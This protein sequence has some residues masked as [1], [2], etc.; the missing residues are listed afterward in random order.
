MEIV[1]EMFSHEERIKKVGGR[2]FG[3]LHDAAQETP[4]EH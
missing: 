4:R 2:N 1:R 3:E